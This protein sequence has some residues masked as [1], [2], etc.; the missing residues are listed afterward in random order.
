VRSTII[1]RARVEFSDTTGGQREG[2]AVAVASPGVTLPE[3]G[4]LSDGVLTRL[5]A[6]EL[7]Q[8]TAFPVDF[9]P[10]KAAWDYAIRPTT[11]LY[12]AYQGYGVVNRDSRDLAH[13][14]LLGEA[15]MPD[16]AEVDGFI[17]TADTLRNAFWGNP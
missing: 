17:A 6:E 7:V 2:Q 8:K 11:D 12:Y 9:D 13:Q 15:P 1:E 10:Q 4:P 3:S 5:E 14:V 16:R